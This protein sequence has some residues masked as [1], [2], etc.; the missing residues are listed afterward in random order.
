MTDIADMTSILIIDN[1]RALRAV[2]GEGLREAG[3]VVQEAA[4][5]RLGVNAFRK[6]PTDLVITDLYMPERDG[7][8]VIEALRRTNP[9]VP[10]L[11][12][13]GASGTMDYL[14]VALTRGA[15]EIL[16]KPFSVSTVV[17]ILDRIFAHT[18]QRTLP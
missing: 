5:G 13:S 8:E 1:D 2:L 18:S 9:Q 15:T 4:N 3:Y 12:I 6:A 11:A 10:I 17:R 16:S 7:L 14:K